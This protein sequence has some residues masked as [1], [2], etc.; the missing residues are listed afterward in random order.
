[1]LNTC[2]IEMIHLAE[3]INFRFVVIG[4]FFAVF[5]ISASWAQPNLAWAKSA[6]GSGDDFVYSVK[7]DNAGNV[8]STGYFYN[9]VDFDPGAG[10]SN[11][12]QEGNGDIFVLKLDASGNF[13][14]AR[15]MG[16]SLP[17]RGVDISV[18]NA[19]NVYTV[20]FFNDTT[21][22]DPGVGTFNL[23]SAGQR[24]IFISKLDASGNFVWAGSIGG[25][26][27][28][29][30]NSIELDASGNLHITGGFN[31]MADFDP[32]VGSFNLTPVG[33]T[34][35]FVLKLDAAGSFIWAKG[36]GSTT[37]DFA[38]SIALDAS[39]NVIT[40]GRFS[41]TGD[42]DPGAGVSNLSTTGGD[43]VF[44]SK[45][46]SNGDFVWAKN[47]GSLSASD[48]AYSVA[49]DNNG[50][51]Y[52]TGEFGATADFDPGAGT[53][54]ISSVSAGIDV[55]ISKLDSSGNF[56]WAKSIGG[57]GLEA[58]NSIAVD[59]SGNV[60]TSGSFTDS[61]DFDPGVGIVEL[62]SAGS[63]EVFISIL[64]PSGNYI[65]ADKIGSVSIDNGFSIATDASDN[66]YCAGQFNSTVDFDPGPAIF[67]LTAS[68]NDFFIM[69]L[70]S[71]SVGTI[72]YDEESMVIYPNPGSGMFNLSSSLIPCSNAKLYL[73]NLMG[74]VMY[75]GTLN[76]QNQ[77]LDFSDMPSGNYYLLVRNGEKQ[78]IKPVII[79][80]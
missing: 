16:G 57:P 50:N 26:N 23:T 12:T 32:G 46:N 73:M 59:A 11:L 30:A 8:Y 18:D 39:G 47:F 79:V 44:V 34:D 40:T 56:V 20:G 69:K 42:F 74:K 65:W 28:D 25:T 55:F 24:D 70:G 54:N 68:P 21:D 52:T 31:G 35:I 43:D 29:Y 3:K 62:V 75:S 14:W 7:V 33:N 13:V 36:M 17:D 2:K 66:I 49:I 63:S 38:N 71:F 10:I 78:L 5:G 72:T 80:K 9:T 77:Q 64:D 67:N 61:A 37:V 19:G 1:M 53:F 27:N 4:L 48:E 6:G 76:S 51:I 45:L 60:Y 15:S 58:G 22:F 41:G